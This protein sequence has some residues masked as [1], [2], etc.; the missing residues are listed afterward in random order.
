MS[1]VYRCSLLPQA[2]CPAFQLSAN[3]VSLSWI[4]RAERRP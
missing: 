2:G 1:G 3:F 4:G